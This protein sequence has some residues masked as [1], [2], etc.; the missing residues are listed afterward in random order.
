VCRPPE[1]KVLPRYRGAIPDNR[2]C[3]ACDS[4]K[5]ASVQ[6]TAL[7]SE[8]LECQDCL[9]ANEVKFGPDGG[10]RLVAV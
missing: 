5:L 1:A 10:V 8:L 3:P 7:E 6:N 4:T 9:Q 2:R